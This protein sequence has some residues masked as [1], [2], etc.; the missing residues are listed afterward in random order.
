MGLVGLTD[1]GA[2]GPHDLGQGLPCRFNGPKTAG[3][4]LP[5][6]LVFSLLILD[7][8]EEGRLP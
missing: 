4:V 5:Y 6:A 3:Q 2:A 1:R 8:E 7:S